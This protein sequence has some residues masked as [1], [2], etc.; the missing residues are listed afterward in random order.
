MR[1]KDALFSGEEGSPDSV[2]Y[3]L[4]FLKLRSVLLQ[5]TIR[6]ALPSSLSTQKQISCCYQRSA[7][8]SVKPLSSSVVFQHPSVSAPILR[9]YAKLE[10]QPALLRGASYITREVPLGSR[11]LPPKASL[12][13]SRRLSRPVAIYWLFSRR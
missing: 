4:V 11:S 3:T 7:Y 10:I 6:V 8:C 9:A 13:G 5:A 12:L 1:M 2:R